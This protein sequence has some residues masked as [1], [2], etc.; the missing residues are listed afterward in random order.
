MLADQAPVGTDAP[1]FCPWCGT[2]SP[3]RSDP[4]TPLW[5]RAADEKG[6]EPPQ[7]LDEVLHIDA[8]VTGCGKCRRVSHVIGHEARMA[9]G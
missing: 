1:R 9:T 2:A 4:H 7:V 8:Y 5:R 6:T 3:F